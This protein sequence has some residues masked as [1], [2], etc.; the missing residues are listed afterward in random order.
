MSNTITLSFG[1]TSVVLNYIDPKTIY[2]DRPK[3]FTEHVLQD[4]TKTVDEAPNSKRIWVINH[5]VALTDAERTDLNTLC[6][7][8]QNIT[9]V[10]DWV[11]A[12]TYNVHFRSLDQRFDQ[13]QAGTKYVMEFVEL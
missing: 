2:P 12:G 6:Y 8:H 11:D 13:A 7:T 3:N 10:E 5:D 4:G 9:L 1:A